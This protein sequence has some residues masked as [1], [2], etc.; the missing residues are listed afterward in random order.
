MWFD[1]YIS[2]VVGDGRNISFWKDVWV[3]KDTLKA[4]FSRLFLLSEQ[5]EAKVIDMGFWEEGEWSWNFRWRR[6]FFVWENDI[7]NTLQG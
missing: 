2:R 1:A 3:G 7:F 6:K 4:K 5:Q